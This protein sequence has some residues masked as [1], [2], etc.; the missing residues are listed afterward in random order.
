MSGDMKSVKENLEMIQTEIARACENSNRSPGEIRVVSVTKKQNLETLK[1]ALG[2]GLRDFAENYQQEAAEKQLALS[3]ENI[4]WHFIGGIQTNKL[5]TIVGAFQWIHSVDRIKVAT[6]ID[7]LCQQ[8]GCRQ[9]VLLQVNMAG[10][11]SKSGIAPKDVLP[12]FDQVETLQNLDWAGLMLMP[13]FVQDAEQNRNFFRQGQL[14]LMQILEKKAWLS[15][16]SFRE[17]S[18]GTSQDYGVAIEEGATMIRVGEKLL[19]KRV[20]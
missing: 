4:D 15:S 3:D 16:E 13:P 9:K 7:R 1:Q 20:V 14:L 8:R 12:F 19:G 10:E 18:M 11:Q 17:L 5:K 2:A 6:E